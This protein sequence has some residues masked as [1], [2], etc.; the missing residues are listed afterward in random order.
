MKNKFFPGV[1]T[2][3]E[4]RDWRGRLNEIK[5]EIFHQTKKGKVDF[6]S[7]LA[8]DVLKK[9]VPQDDFQNWHDFLLEQKDNFQKELDLVIKY[10]EGYERCE[11]TVA[12]PLSKAAYE[13][14][15]N[16]FRNQNILRVIVEVKVDSTVGGGAIIAL[17]GKI[18][19]Y[20]LR[21]KIAADL[22]RI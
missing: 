1:L 18:Y 8:S 4:A 17:G 5:D 22:K 19:D 14:L 3:A 16:W 9:H 15:V 20:S 2:R 13:R 7:E 21:K 10:L 11:V 6:S 12:R